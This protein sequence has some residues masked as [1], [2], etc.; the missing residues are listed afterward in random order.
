MYTYIPICIDWMEKNMECYVLNEENDCKI[1]IYLMILYIKEE[2]R[3]HVVDIHP[4]VL[5]QFLQITVLY[6]RPLLYFYL[7][8]ETR[9]S[10]L[11]S[12]CTLHFGQAFLHPLVSCPHL[13]TICLNCPAPIIHIIYGSTCT[14]KKRWKLSES[15]R[16][17]HC[18]LWWHGERWGWKCM[19]SAFLNFSYFIC[20]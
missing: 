17:E 13:S 10:Q 20:F 3:H 1:R 5:L 18:F 11:S 16:N 15:I 7:C 9:G 14:K 12:L 19:K 2:A 6:P 4:T 8:C